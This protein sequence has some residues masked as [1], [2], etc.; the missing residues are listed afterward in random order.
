MFDPTGKVALVTG[1]GAF[2]GEVGTGSPSA[3]ATQKNG[4]AH[5]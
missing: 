4:S 3:K 5:V 1:A 2:A